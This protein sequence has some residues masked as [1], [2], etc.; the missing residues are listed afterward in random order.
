MC[1]KINDMCSRVYFGSAPIVQ[2]AHET[3]GKM[4]LCS[5]CASS[6]VTFAPSVLISEEP[7]VCHCSPCLFAQR[8]GEGASDSVKQQA[9][10]DLRE[11]VDR[12]IERE[13][14]VMAQRARRAFS[15]EVIRSIV[16]TTKHLDFSAPRDASPED[17]VLAVGQHIQSKIAL[18]RFYSPNVQPVNRI[19]YSGTLK[20]RCAVFMALLHAVG[21][22]T[23]TVFSVH[24]QD[25]ENV[26]WAE[27]L[28]QVN[29]S[30]QWKCVSIEGSTC[31]ITDVPARPHV[32]HVLVAIEASGYLTD[33]TPQNSRAT[34][35]P[36]VL[37]SQL[38]E[39]NIQLVEANP[40]LSE[41]AAPEI[42]SASASLAAELA[43]A[44]SNATNLDRSCED[45]MTANRQ[46][47]NTTVD[48]DS[49]VPLRSVLGEDQLVQQLH[50]AAY[51]NDPSEML[52]CPKAFELLDRA[53]NNWHREDKY[54]V[55]RLQ[56]YI[57]SVL[58]RSNCSAAG[59]LLGTSGGFI[60]CAKRLAHHSQ[61][62]PMPLLVALVSSCTNI[63]T[64]AADQAFAFRILPDVLDVLAHATRRASDSQVLLYGL[65]QAT[66]ATMETLMAVGTADGIAPADIDHVVRA[67]LGLLNDLIFAGIK[68]CALFPSVSN[69]I[70]S[71]ASGLFDGNKQLVR[72]LLGHAV[73]CAVQRIPFPELRQAA[74]S[75]IFH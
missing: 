27:C 19:F 1:A 4:I 38:L 45:F 61:Q 9:L 32:G 21:I 6:C 47:C 36:S 20:E 50:Y 39:H 75:E 72:D 15:A 46:L 69:A 71:V 12:I 65:F 28:L 55:V 67:L 31:Q 68:K 7:F 40:Q 17:K 3:S 14:E 58:I 24:G 59:E 73:R 26:C 66:Q 63:L 18:T 51:C 62:S 35:R 25:G 56:D 23:R 2:P 5:G 30:P 42:S 13:T 48:N 8:H 52:K 41:R 11:D 10:R 16:A 54:L 64:K 44:F 60:E 70:S 53:L 29:S 37:A 57:F 74:E 49:L 34:Y 43:Q 33:A 22:E